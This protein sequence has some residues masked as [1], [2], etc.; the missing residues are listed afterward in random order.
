MT[1]AWQHCVKNRLD[2]EGDG[3][4]LTPPQKHTVWG[5]ESRLNMGEKTWVNGELALS[6][7][8][9]NTYSHVDRKETSQAW[10]LI[11]YTGWDIPTGIEKTTS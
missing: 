5:L 9:K 11:G 10:K 6:A 3:T 2:P 7:I 4:L 8:D 1:R